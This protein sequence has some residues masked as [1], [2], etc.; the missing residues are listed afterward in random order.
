MCN[1]IPRK[2]SED[3]YGNHYI[4]A[5]D[6]YYE[7]NI[8]FVPLTNIYAS[9][10]LHSPPIINENEMIDY[11]ELNKENMVNSKIYLIP[12]HPNFLYLKYEFESNKLY[13]GYENISK[14]NESRANINDELLVSND[15]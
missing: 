4:S 1:L 13:N 11:H 5:K 7:K 8:F 10:Y 15:D 14:K 9:A 6:H 12:L 2:V 3:K